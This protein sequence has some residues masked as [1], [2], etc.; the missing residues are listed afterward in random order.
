MS[1]PL[2]SLLVPFYNESSMVDEFFETVTGALDADLA[3]F[4]FIC[5]DDGSSD[6][7]LEKLLA[8][9]EQ[10]TRVKVL[11]F[12]RNFG[13][14]A[15]LTAALDHAN[16]DAAIPMDAD[17]QDPPELVNEMITKWQEGYEVVFAQRDARAN[18]SMLKR[19]TADLFY[20]IFNTISEN[21]I[22]PHVGDFR[23]MSRRVMDV[24]KS[25][26]E[27]ERFM[28]GLFS[29][30][31]FKST[32]ISYE[33]PRRARGSTKFNYWKLW[34]FALSGLTSFSTVPIRLGTYLGLLIAGCAFLYATYVV[35]KTLVLG[36]DV[37]G[38][39]SL[40]TI[41]LFLGGVQLFVI[42]LMGEYLGRIYREVKGRPLYVIDRKTGFDSE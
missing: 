33:R 24:V 17:L 19:H 1:K 38:Y 25:L 20:R 23:L 3:E 29:W 4:E 12:S 32:A 22:P 34:N 40:I 21:P 6:D 42:G 15:A 35:L 39:A 14:E 5:V 13:K 7:T 27:R 10:D 8:R 36:I 9:A 41:I 37:P 26:P 2:V 28:K 11:S 31:G 18:D 16:G 30:P